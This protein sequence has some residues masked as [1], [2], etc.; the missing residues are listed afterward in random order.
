MWVVWVWS[1][2]WEDP[3]EEGMATHSSILAWR[4]PMVRG[5]WGTPPWG[6][7]RVRLNWATKQACYRSLC[8]S[9]LQF[10][11]WYLSLLSKTVKF[12]WILPHYTMAWKLLLSKLRLLIC[13]NSFVS[14]FPGSTVL[15]C[16]LSEIIFCVYFI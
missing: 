12:F 4:I 15:I 1:L 2:S 3:L 10:I 8:A 11:S 7:Q 6:S 13:L 9:Y 16:K 5:A 14:I